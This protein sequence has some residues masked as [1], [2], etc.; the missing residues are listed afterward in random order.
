LEN[1]PSVRPASG[2]HIQRKIKEL[3]DPNNLGD[4]YYETIPESIKE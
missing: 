3:I 4:R 2:F 1:I